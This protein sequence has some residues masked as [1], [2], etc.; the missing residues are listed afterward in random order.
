M[1]VDQHA[2]VG[3]ALVLVARTTVPEPLA[4]VEPV[5]RIIRE[6]NPDVPLRAETM[7]ATMEG[8]SATPRFRTVVLGIFAVV[9]LLLSM[10]GIYGV[11]A[12]I[13]GHRVPEIGLRVALGATPRDVFALVVGQ[14]GRLWAM[15]L[16]LGLILSLAVWRT[17]DGL[18]FGVSAADPLVL[19]GVVGGITVSALAACY[20]PV[21]RALAVEPATA[22]RTE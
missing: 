4:L 8:A 10:V 19:A 5:R 9:A 1:P 18:L 20:L 15:G 17:L 6:K 13:V 11:M 21:R 2:L 16:G 7:D 14:G 22:L 3:T 12:Y